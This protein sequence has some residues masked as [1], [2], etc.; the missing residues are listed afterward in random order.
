MNNGQQSGFA[1]WYRARHSAHW[2]QVCR[3]DSEAEC[4]RLLALRAPAD[5]HREL[6]VTPLGTN[7]NERR[8]RMQTATATLP[9]M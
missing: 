5:Q 4:W 9:G 7:P 2:Q 8:P 1:G 3:G 6:I